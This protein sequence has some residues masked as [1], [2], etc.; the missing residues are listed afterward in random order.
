MPNG[1]ASPTTG[2]NRVAGACLVAGAALIWSSGGLIVRL[3]SGVDSWT[4]VFWRST[5]A[6]VF[7]I[8]FGLYTQGSGFL[9]AVL[10]MRLPGLGIALCYVVASISL[11]VALKLTTVADVLILMSCAPLLAALLGR[12]IL[13]EELGV[14]GWIALAG[15]VLGAGIMV[16]D[17]Y[18]HGSIA[19]DLVAMA[20]ALAQ[21]VAIV[22]FRRHR[23]VS[24]IPGIS[25]AMLVAALLVAPLAN[26]AP[27]ALPQAGLIGLFGA[28]QL[29]LG[30]VLFASGA[31][32][33]PAAETA[34]FGVL[35]PVIGP[36]WVWLAL[37][38]KP[39]PAGLLGGA[40]VI[41]ALVLFTL[42]SLRD[43]PRMADP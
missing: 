38:E 10:Q 27:I 2:S 6:L 40:I 32:L 22:L 12:M 13:A 11:I 34:M 26:F 36:I 29:G 7:L 14:L 18:A 1:A 9:R 43:G 37:G 19:G 30:L 39:S 15:S 20:I 24:M 16:S 28:G 33:I 5:A 4:I 3:L 31:R 25:L 21:A 42:S 17:S 41:G 23:D 8:I 35:E